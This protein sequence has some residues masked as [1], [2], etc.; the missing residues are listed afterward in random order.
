MLRLI[1]RQLLITRCF[2]LYVL[3]KEKLGSDNWLGLKR[4][5]RIYLHC[6]WTTPFWLNYFLKVLQESYLN[7]VKVLPSVKWNHII[8]R[9][10]SY[11]L[12][13]WIGCSV[14]CQSCFPWDKLKQR[15]INQLWQKLTLNIVQEQ[16]LN[17]F[18]PVMNNWKINA[19]LK[20]YWVFLIRKKVLILSIKNEIQ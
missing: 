9:N 2:I 6:F 19:V 1:N 14:K 12:V 13:S 18:N 20:S 4:L 11:W 17:S 5:I 10:P 16:Y 3:C 8:G 15:K 7:F